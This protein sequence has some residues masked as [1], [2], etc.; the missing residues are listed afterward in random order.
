M[1]NSLINSMNIVVIWLNYHTVTERPGDNIVLNQKQL[2]VEKLPENHGYNLKSVHEL[3]NL[4]NIIR[5]LR[6]R[7]FSACCS[8]MQRV[9]AWVWSPGVPLAAIF[10]LQCVAVCCSVLQ[11][12]AACCSVLHCVAITM[13]CILL[14]RVAVYCNVS[15]HHHSVSSLFVRDAV[16]CSVL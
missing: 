5:S 2:S 12:A 6:S 4:K 1:V 11:C 10:V 7:H 15:V 9:A 13:C 16:C 3:F 8:V 14:Q